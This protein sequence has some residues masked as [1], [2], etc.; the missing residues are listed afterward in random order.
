MR[1]LFAYAS[2][3]PTRTFLMLGSLML[4][5]VAEGLGLTTLL[6]LLS[7][8][9]G[10]PHKSGLSHKVMEVLS[11]LHLAPTIG[12]MLSIIVAGMVLKSALVLLANR[13]VGYTVAHVATDLRLELIRALLGSRWEYYI[14]QPTGSLANSVATE[15]YRASTG[16]E[17][18]ANVIALLIQVGVYAIVAFLISWQATLVSLC[19]GSLLLGV[20]H[21]LVLAS[22]RAGAKQ[23]RL[24]RSLLAYLTDI[25]GSVKPLKAMARHNV[26]DALLQEQTTRLNRAMR[27]EV[28]ARE[29][30]R[31]LQEPMV[32]ILAAVG[33]YVALV[34]WGLSLTSVMVL[35]FLLARVLGLMNRLQRRYQ[36]MVT[37]ESAYWSLRAAVRHARNEAEDDGGTRAPTL[38]QGI[39]FERIHFSY[40]G[41][42]VL[43]GLD[44]DIPAGSFVTL[45]GP[46]GAGKTTVLDLLCGLLEPDDGRILVDGVPIGELDRRQWRRLIGYVPQETLLLHD[47]VLVNVTLGDATLGEQDAER[48]LRQAGAWEFVSAMPEGVHSVVGER[49]AKLSGGQRQR[50]VIARALAHRP[51]LLILD[52]ATSALDPDSEAAICRSLEALAGELTIV[53]VSHQPALVLMAERVYRL[54]R[55]RATPVDHAATTV[56]ASRTGTHPVE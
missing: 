23:T 25:L 41:S 3:Y 24:M 30:L 35:T 26:A 51:R 29:A 12:V 13:Q 45:T 5:G 44:L 56:T 43:R 22:R 46:S 2:A 39:R 54:D 19:V 8:A 6:P 4:A 14:K 7:V 38:T 33:L 11:T 50:V 17:H 21:W 16:Y 36:L 49:G 10:H 42:P 55:G 48:A 9:V 32:T 20:L 28:I 37:Q 40:A 18:G 52:E 1:I 15:A 53:A 27:R 47:S 34:L 31:A